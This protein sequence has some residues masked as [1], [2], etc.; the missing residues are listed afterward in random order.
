[1][2]DK[3]VPNDHGNAGHPGD[4]GVPDSDSAEEASRTAEDTKTEDGQDEE[5]D[6]GEASGTCGNQLATASSPNTQVPG[7]FQR[8]EVLSGIR[9]GARLN[10]PQDEPQEQDGN[11]PNQGNGR[12]MPIATQLA[13]ENNVR[14]DDIIA[15]D[16]DII[17]AVAT[18]PDPWWRRNQ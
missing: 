2:E 10:S 14:H 4:A 18:D 1:M 15:T 13:D 9:G 7:A 3:S 17:V 8:R 5:V 6:K 12:D 16:N 11:T